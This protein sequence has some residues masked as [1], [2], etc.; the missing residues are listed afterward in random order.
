MV[1]R[2]VPRRVRKVADELPDRVAGQREVGLEDPC[3]LAGLAVDGAGEAHD[4]RALRAGGVGH[5]RPA[6]RGD[7][8]VMDDS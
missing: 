2:R 3:V 6:V 4:A 7:P 8:E 5:R 1:R